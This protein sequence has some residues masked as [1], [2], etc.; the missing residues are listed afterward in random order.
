MNFG[1][2]SGL[3][4]W[5][6]GDKEVINI[7]KTTSVMRYLQRVGSVSQSMFK[8]DSRSLGYVKLNQYITQN[9]NI[10]FRLAMV[11]DKYI[12]YVRKYLKC[13]TEDGSVK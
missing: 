2:E 9:N 4:I 3:M 5:S 6:K 12:N 8:T 10:Y 1:N 13:L 11:S 7:N